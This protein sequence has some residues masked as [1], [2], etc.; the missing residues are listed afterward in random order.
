MIIE[1]NDIFRHNNYIIHIMS[2]ICLTIAVSFFYSNGS[3]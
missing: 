1:S 2:F 3:F